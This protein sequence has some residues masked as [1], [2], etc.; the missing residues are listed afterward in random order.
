MAAALV[1][2]SC[3][4]GLYAWMV[5]CSGSSR[6]AAWLLLKRANTDSW[7]DALK[8]WPDCT[9]PFELQKVCDCAT[10]THIL[11]LLR[12]GG[13]ANIYTGA[14]HAYAVTYVLS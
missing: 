5:N 14:T 11:D 6:Q 2:S 12:E 8:A 7:F 10:E 13:G 9:R 4:E 3:E 1:R